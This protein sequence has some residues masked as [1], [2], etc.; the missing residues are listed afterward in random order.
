MP[1][2][3]CPHTVTFRTV[4]TRDT[5]RETRRERIEEEG[6][7]KKKPEQDGEGGRDATLEGD[8]TPC[9]SHNV[10]AAGVL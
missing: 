7:E 6:K 2:A 5:H 4:C 1:Y 10:A 9:M 8:G 3:N